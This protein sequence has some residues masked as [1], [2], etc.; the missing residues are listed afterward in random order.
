MKEFLAEGMNRYKQASKVMMEFFKNTQAELQEILKR[1]KEW[2][3]TF[4]RK[5]II[6]VK[7]TKFWDEYPLI[8][9][10]IE[11]TIDGKTARIQISINWFRSDLEYPYYSIEFYDAPEKFYKNISYEKQ[12]KYELLDQNWLIFYPDP[13]DFNLDRDFN[14]LID[15]FLSAISAKK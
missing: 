3:D 1:K 11:G 5:E 15:E 9:A 4:K 8:N 14:L 6:T 13:K 7:S 10:Q 2:G 12:G